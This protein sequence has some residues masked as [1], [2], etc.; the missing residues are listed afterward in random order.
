MRR[1]LLNQR[2]ERHIEEDI[3]ALGIVDDEADLFGEQ[4]RVHRVQDGA[5]ACDAEIDLQVPVVI[6]RQR[7]DTLTAVH[8]ETLQRVGD[9]PGPSRD[10][11]PVAAKRSAPPPIGRRSRSRVVALGVVEQRR[12]QQRPLLH[13]PEHGGRS[14]TASCWWRSNRPALPG[15]SG[16]GS[17]RNTQR[18]A[19]GAVRLRRTGR[20]CA[21]SG[22]RRCAGITASL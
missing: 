12:D 3:A 11:R 16:D 17:M 10:C 20:A 2:G 4:S 9:A 5:T 22:M 21:G 1:E 13:Q 15:S 7:G 6:P 18:G 19:D 14:L 8:A